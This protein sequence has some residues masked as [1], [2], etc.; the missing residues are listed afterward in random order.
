MRILMLALA[1]VGSSLAGIAQAQPT[2]CYGVYG[3]AEWLYLR[4]YNADLVFNTIATEF[5]MNNG[6]NTTISDRD[7]ICARPHYDSGVRVWLGYQSPCS[8][9]GLRGDYLYHESSYS[10]RLAGEVDQSQTRVAERNRVEY[11]R[12]AVEWTSRLSSCQSPCTV[13]G[14]IG[15]GWAEVTRTRRVEGFVENP[16]G[17][18]DTTTRNHLYFSGVGP[19][20]GADLTWQLPCWSA[21]SLHGAVACTV[22]IAKSNA[23]RRFEDRFGNPEPFSLFLEDDKQDSCYR[24]V[25]S[26]EVKVGL[27]GSW[28]CGCTQIMGEVGYRVDT[29]SNALG[30]DIPRP[31]LDATPAMAA[32]VVDASVSDAGTFNPRNDIGFG[33]LYLGLQVGF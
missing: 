13:V 24:T 11:Q 30:G 21:I 3:G 6:F 18:R 10:A 8:C 17:V 12:A 7:R 28:C 32:E 29:Y 16:T 27:Q 2:C 4:P 5:F 33:G 31:G 19:R 14:V 25:P 22:L 15:V 26:F 1:V 23:N 20:A 9:W